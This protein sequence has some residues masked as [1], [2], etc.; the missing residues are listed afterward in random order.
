LSLDQVGGKA[1]LGEKVAALGVVPGQPRTFT[2]NE[3]VISAASRNHGKR[4]QFTSMANCGNSGGMVINADGALLGLVLEPMQAGR[5]M[6][7][8]LGMRPYPQSG[9]PFIGRVVPLGARDNSV[10]LSMWQIAPN[11]GIG[12]GAAVSAIL[13]SLETMK[14]GKDI[15]RE[16]TAYVGIKPALN[17]QNMFKDE[18]IIGEVIKGSPAASAGIK[19]GDRVLRLN[20][21]PVVNW[22]QF[23]DAVMDFDVGDTISLTLQRKG[24]PSYLEVNGEA[25]RNQKD[26]A[27]LLD[28]LQ[29]GEEFT[30]RK[31]QKDQDEVTVEV[32]LGEQP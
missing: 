2:L 18:I 3:G 4:F 21:Q 19:T 25:V 26:L 5:L 8:K 6:E 31:V 32:I 28:R 29:P 16:A 27:K 11:S 24:G 7:T 9:G 13:E 30:G 14:T 15:V 12:F 20:E 10:S 17:Q 23:M 22:K 1:A